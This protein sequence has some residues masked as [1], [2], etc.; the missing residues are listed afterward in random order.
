MTDIVASTRAELIRLRRWP[1]VW[2]V[3]G[4][5]F[6]LILLFDFVFNYISYRT[7]STNFATDGDTTESLLHEMLL[8]NLPSAFIQGMPMFGGALMMVLGALVAGSGYQWGTWKTAFLTGPSRGS[9]VGGTIVAVAVWVSA[10][11]TAG[12]LM[13]VGL[14]TLVGAIE[15]QPFELPVMG[16]MARSFL[17]GLLVMLTFALL[18]MLLGTLLRGPALALGLGLV[19][20]LII[21]Q[22]LRGIGASLSAVTWVTDLLPGT[23]AGS[24]VGS[25]TDPEEFGSTPGVLDA[26]SG[27]RAALT[28]GLYAVLVPIAVV[29]V[30]RRRDVS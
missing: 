6:L 4:V 30:M 23:A 2:A 17:I 21:E 7:G 22:L 11:V 29:A 19:W 27:G 12:L 16:D 14:S 28:L 18:G 26:L 10:V 8:P 20:A 9:V 25:L 15:G 13:H 3:S 5:W 1:A 24:L